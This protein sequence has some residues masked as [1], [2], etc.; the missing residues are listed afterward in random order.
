MTASSAHV[1]SIKLKGLSVISRNL[2]LWQHDGDDDDDDGPFVPPSDILEAICPNECYDRGECV[3]GKM[4]KSID[5]F[6]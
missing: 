2:S 4:F 5:Q 1:D 3:K 6:K